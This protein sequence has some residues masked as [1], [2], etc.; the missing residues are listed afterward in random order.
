MPDSN[1]AH[2]AARHPRITASMIQPEVPSGDNRSAPFKSPTPRPPLTQTPK[3]SD[4]FTEHPNRAAL[5]RMRR[6]SRDRRLSGLGLPVVQRIRIPQQFMNAF[7][8]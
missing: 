8:S 1:I 7:T 3:V 4:H 5:S 2:S 6:K